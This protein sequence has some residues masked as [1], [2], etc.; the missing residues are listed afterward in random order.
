LIKI[1]AIYKA[2]NHR[3]TTNEFISGFA[4]PVSLLTGSTIIAQL[5]SV[6]IYPILTRLY[7][8]LAFGLLTLFLSYVSVGTEIAPLG[9]QYAIVGAKQLEDKSLLSALSLINSVIFSIILALVLYILIRGNILGFGILPDWSVW[10]AIPVI[11]L[12]AILNILRYGLI[13]EGSF[14]LISKVTVYQSIGKS[15]SLVILGVL[16]LGSFSLFLCEVLGRFFG[17]QEMFRKVWVGLKSDL[18]IWFNKKNLLKVIKDY[19][20]YPLFSLP[21]TI[22][23]IVA[24]NIFIPIIVELFGISIAGQIGLV[25]KIITMP[26]ALISRSVSDVFHNQVAVLVKEKPQKIPALLIKTCCSLLLLGILPSAII[27]FLAPPLFPRILGPQW[28][29]SGLIASAIV[30][31]TLAGFIVSPVSRLIFVSDWQEY[32]FIYDLL[33]LGF[34]LLALYGGKF[35]RFD[36]IQSLTLLSTLQI[37]SYL[38]YFILLLRIAYHP[39]KVPKPN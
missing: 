14:T 20:R 33:A 29:M 35:F 26:F 13:K 8:P 19:Y 15:I 16:S 12:S 22:L 31:W 11:F 24:A 23:D 2:I 28:Q 4:R 18:Q 17:L 39:F 32:K 9:Y 3:I 7:T 5:L 36:V 27:F 10:F 6:L 34:T 1:F 37:F 30:P 25:Q 38:V 21:S